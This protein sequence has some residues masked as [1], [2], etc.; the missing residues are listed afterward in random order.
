MI[1]EERDR[2][3]VAKFARLAIEHGDRFDE[4]DLIGWGRF[5]HWPVVAQPHRF[6]PAGRRH[7][8][9]C[10]QLRFRRRARRRS[11]HHHRATIDL[12]PAR[13]RSSPPNCLNRRTSCFRIA[14][15][16]PRGRAQSLH[17]NAAEHDAE[18]SEIHVVFARTAVEH[19]GQK[20]HL[21]QQRIG[22]RRRKK[23]ASRNGGRSRFE[24]VVV[25]QLRQQSLKV[26]LWRGS[27]DRFRTTTVQDRC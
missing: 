19:H 25:E 22:D 23:F 4:G 5:R 6:V 8:L 18:R 15:M 17:E 14:R 2:V 20:Q 12:T 3:V 24:I 7:D 13:S 16:P 21:D 11:H 9:A 10:R 26:V 27:S 1:V